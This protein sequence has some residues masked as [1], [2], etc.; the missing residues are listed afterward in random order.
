MAAPRTYNWLWYRLTLPPSKSP[1][2]FF[3][4]CFCNSVYGYL[5]RIITGKREM[6][7]KTGNG[8]YL[9]MPTCKN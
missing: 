9:I 3:R 6:G 8:L 4:N 5:I 7:D 2:Q 1:F